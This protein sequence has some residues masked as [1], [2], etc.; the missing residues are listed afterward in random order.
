VVDFWHFST[1]GIREKIDIVII[2]PC[3]VLNQID[4]FIIISFYVD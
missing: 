2:L 1:M 4:E 3:E